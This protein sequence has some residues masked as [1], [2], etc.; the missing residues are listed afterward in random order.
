M[1][2]S[3][4]TVSSGNIHHSSMAS[5]TGCRVNI[6]PFQHDF[7]KSYRGS[8]A[9]ASEALPPPLLTSLFLPFVYC[10]LP[11]LNEIFLDTPPAYP[12]VGQFWSHTGQSLTSCAPEGCSLLQNCTLAGWDGVNFLHISLCNVLLRKLSL[13]QPLIFPHLF[14]D[15]SP[16][17]LEV[18]KKVREWLPA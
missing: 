8:S 3:W 16:N 10:A 7:S 13:S 6:Y 12:V 1:G 17:P 4:A 18:W 2:S 9:P 14:L 5:P 11:F 15:S